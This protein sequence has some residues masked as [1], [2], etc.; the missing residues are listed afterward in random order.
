[1]EVPR[2]RSG[3][4]DLTTGGERSYDQPLRTLFTPVADIDAF[5]V[6]RPRRPEAG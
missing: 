1:M 2:G 6:S 5:A 3:D 4:Y